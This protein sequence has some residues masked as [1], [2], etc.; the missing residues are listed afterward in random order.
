MVYGGSLTYAVDK[1]F[2]EFFA[3]L[4]ET[5]PVEANI[6]PQLAPGAGE[7]GETLAIVGVTWCGDHATGEKALAPVL[8]FPGLKSGK[9]APFAYHDIQ[10]SAD[11]FLGHGKQYYLKSGFLNELTAGCHRCHRRIREPWRS[12]VMVSAHG[13]RHSD[14]CSRRDGFHTSRRCV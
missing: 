13:R 7:N 10:T 1:D 11:G 5:L 2:L 12:Q 8:A 14:S 3:E 6:E 9:L 4:H